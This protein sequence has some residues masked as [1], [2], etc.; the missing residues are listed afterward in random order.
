M[1][2]QTDVEI[3]MKFVTEKVRL[4]MQDKSSILKNLK[5]EVLGFIKEIK[6]IHL[7]KDDLI[8]PGDNC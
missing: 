4:E 2:K 1:T 8:G 6:S 3:L 5:N 7:Q